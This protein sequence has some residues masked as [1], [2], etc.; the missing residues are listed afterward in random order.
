MVTGRA[1]V[2]SQVG[3]IWLA[4]HILPLFI[5]LPAR[6]GPGPNL[7]GLLLCLSPA[8]TYTALPWAGGQGG[9]ALIV[10][11]LFSRI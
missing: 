1:G 9:C 6:P 11:K 5:P 3:C 4:L 2:T 10:Q 8:L 7:I